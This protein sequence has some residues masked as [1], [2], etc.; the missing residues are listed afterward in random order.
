MT[1]AKPQTCLFRMVNSDV[2]CVWH[3]S[4]NPCPLE[5]TRELAKGRDI[6]EVPPRVHSAAAAQTRCLA[7]V[8]ASTHS[9]YGDPGQILTP[10]VPLQETEM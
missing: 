2:C 6:A 9:V 10:V 4:L 5:W 1:G 3:K 7:L 8:A